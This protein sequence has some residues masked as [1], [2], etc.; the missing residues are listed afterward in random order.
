MFA[1]AISDLP[2]CI[3]TLRTDY[4]D[5][6]PGLIQSKKLLCPLCSRNGQKQYIMDTMLWKDGKTNRLRPRLILDIG[7]PVVLIPK[8]YCCVS[9]HREI[10]S[11]DPDILQQLPDVHVD[12]FMSHKS[13]ITKDLL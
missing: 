3:N 4:R 8:L 12:F 13:G 6:A 7:S 9:G 5:I 2:S 10:V 1:G 11:C